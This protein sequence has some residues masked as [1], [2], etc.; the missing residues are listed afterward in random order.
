MFDLSFI[1]LGVIY[2]DIYD[3]NIIVNYYDGKLYL[4]E[5][6]MEENGVKVKFGFIDFND[7]VVLL[8]L[9]EVVMVI[10]DLMVDIEDVLYL[11]IGV[12]FL[13]RYIEVFLIFVK[14][15]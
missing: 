2:N 10:R 12:Y 15:L 6:N 1:I 14:E 3:F 8:Y 7:V 9:F 5:C 11:E 4:L 13:I